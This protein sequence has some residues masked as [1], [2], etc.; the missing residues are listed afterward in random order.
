[1]FHVNRILVHELSKTLFRN[2]HH[3]FAAAWRRQNGCCFVPAAR[4]RYLSCE[5]K[6]DQ[7]HT[8][9]L[10]SR[11]EASE[12]VNGAVQ[13]SAVRCSAVQC[14]DDGCISTCVVGVQSRPYRAAPF[15]SA[16]YRTVPS[17]QRDMLSFVCSDISNARP[18][19]L[20]LRVCV[21]VCIGRFDGNAADRV[22]RWLDSSS[23]V[24]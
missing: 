24:L 14:C 13:C 22:T 20:T 16:P 6:R 3:R 18:W 2:V 23:E 10:V 21:S 4:A 9:H 17:P 19:G 5:T 11:D 8:I 15:P 7:T 1:M 12:R